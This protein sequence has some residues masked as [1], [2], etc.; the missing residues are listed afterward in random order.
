MRQAKEEQLIK[1]RAEL[2]ITCI[3]RYIWHKRF[4]KVLVK[5][6]RMKKKEAKKIINSLITGRVLPS[7][8]MQYSE[9]PEL[10]AHRFMTKFD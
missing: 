7:S 1:S 2:L 6:F 5:N 4:K 3:D 9:D 8:E 10:A